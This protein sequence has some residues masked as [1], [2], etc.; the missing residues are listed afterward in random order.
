[1]Y[2]KSNKFNYKEKNDVQYFIALLERLRDLSTMKAI[3]LMT[4]RSSSLRF[5][6]IY[7]D[8]KNV[9]EDSFGLS[10]PEDLTDESYEFSV[11]S[12]ENGRCHGF[13]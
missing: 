4:N 6:P 5:N 3:E 10:L 2:A 7:F 9:T 11:T 8:K 13:L 12:N 1:M